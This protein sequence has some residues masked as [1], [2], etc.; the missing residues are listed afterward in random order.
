MVGPATIAAPG[1]RFHAF[2][3]REQ[4]HIKLA[5]AEVKIT[6]DAAYAL[7]LGQVAEWESRHIR[8][9][10]LFSTNRWQR[11]VRVD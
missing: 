6:I 10:G 9:L 2:L 11:L 4:R 7:G 3:V 5:L 8:A 1:G